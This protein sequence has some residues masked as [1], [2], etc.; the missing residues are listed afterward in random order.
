M[1]DKDHLGEYVTPAMIAAAKLAQS[2]KR[3]PKKK[4]YLRF[5]YW[6]GKT[7]AKAVVTKAIKEQVDD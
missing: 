7:Y 2:R 3:P 4:W 6:A 5:L 1:K